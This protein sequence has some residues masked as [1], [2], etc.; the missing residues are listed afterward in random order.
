[1]SPLTPLASLLFG[2]SLAVFPLHA[3][4]SA[5]K[6]DP[7]LVSFLGRQGYQ[8]EPDLAVLHSPSAVKIDRE[9]L[10]KAGLD[11]NDKGQLVYYGDAFPNKHDIE[12]VDHGTVLKI[13]NNIRPFATAK[14]LSSEKVG[15]IIQGWGFP[16][17]FDGKSILNPD[18]SATYYGLMLY[19]GL[20][21][22][23]SAIKQLSG[24]R[25]AQALDLLK[26]AHSHT[27]DNDGIPERGLQDLERAWRMLA[28]GKLQKGETPLP[29][30]PHG[31]MKTDLVRYKAAVEAAQA[32]GN[33]A[34]SR[35][36]MEKALGA[37]NRLEKTRY[38]K[39][40]DLGPVPPVE[41]DAKDQPG[42]NGVL[43]PQR[44]LH[45]LLKV[46]DKIN[47]KPLNAKEQEW[48]IKS[49]PM[50]ESVWRMGA[51]ELWREEITGK[52][53]RC[54][55]IDAGVGLH[56]DLDDA[57]KARKDFLP[58]KQGGKYKYGEHA[59]HVAGIIRAIAPDCELRS[60]KVILAGENV[61]GDDFGLNDPEHRKAISEA[62]DV[63]VEDGN[64]LINISLRATGRPSD[65]LADE[66]KK[67]TREMGT[68]F[69]ISTFNNGP[70]KVEFPANV[71][72][73]FPVGSIDVNGRLA[74]SSSSGKVWDP[75]LG[76][77]GPAKIYVAP[78]TNIASTLPGD[79][80]DPQP[81]GNRSGTSMA[82]PHGLGALALMLQ[83]ARRI[84][85][86]TDPVALSQKARDA[87]EESSDV[88]SFAL[89]GSERAVDQVHLIIN[90][91]AAYRALRD[92][93]S[94]ADAQP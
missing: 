51:H 32:S 66:I 89:Y 21:D 81:Y 4:D 52:G 20:K 43:P 23:P 16:P 70:G 49:F 40:L 2:L 46:L 47:G 67:Y 84:S 7:E 87:V 9:L 54:G 44:S 6:P 13:L 93:A 53:I 24:E 35:E 77:T 1:M 88:L 74:D 71:A 31:D 22:K 30:K 56:E 64:H 28:S 68:I 33:N 50:G 60:Y 36:E 72:G 65:E 45:I 85:G 80:E 27:F 41:E 48:L 79:A 25:F 73:V 63:A 19:L 11:Y 18:G 29:L 78:G 12:P 75:K 3:A 91:P 59:T 58:H 92:R 62:I 14:G 86:V 39:A 57:V 5:I 34:S 82:T 37:L 42:A 69:F 94:V 55:I 90:P 76:H 61:F 8:F 83:A 17:A 15:R 26:G 10:Q 38:H